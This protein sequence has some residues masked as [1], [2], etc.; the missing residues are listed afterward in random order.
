MMYHLF[1]KERASSSKLGIGKKN[2]AKEGRRGERGKL[3]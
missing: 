2:V 3:A 1:R